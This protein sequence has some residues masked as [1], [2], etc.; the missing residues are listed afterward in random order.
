MEAPSTLLFIER[1][2]GEGR[3]GE[4][5]GGEGRGGEGRGGGKDELTA[6]KL[7]MGRELQCHPHF[8]GEKMS[9]E[10]I[11]NLCK[12]TLLVN[13]RARVRSQVTLTPEDL[14]I[15]SQYIPLHCF[16]GDLCALQSTQAVL[17]KSTG[18]SKSHVL[19]SHHSPA[20]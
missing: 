10:S 15:P 12:V 1:R 13:G 11:R 14:S 6:Y 7:L 2:G 16:S 9:S 5:R 8:I 20:L 18:L 19:N 3:G 17:N 4:E